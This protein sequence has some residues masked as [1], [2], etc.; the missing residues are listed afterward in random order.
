M[1]LDETKM[2]PRAIRAS[3][4]VNTVSNK[5]KPFTVK[6]RSGKSNLV[7]QLFARH[8][9]DV[10]ITQAYQTNVEHGCYGRYT[11]YKIEKHDYA[12][13]MV[14]FVELIEIKDPPE[15]Y[16]PIVIHSHATG[17]GDF[18]MEWENLESAKKAFQNRM[19]LRIQS[20]EKQPGH[21]RTIRLGA[22]TPWFYA[23]GDQDLVGDYVLPI[24]VQDDSEFKLGQQY[25]VFENNL[26]RT[27]V[28]LGTRFIAKHYQEYRSSWSYRRPETVETF[29]LVH[30]S[31]GYIWDEREA[32]NLNRPRPVKTE[33]AWIAEAVKQFQECLAG[34]RTDVNVKFADG[35]QF[36][37]KFKSARITKHSKAG[38]YEIK[39]MVS[40]SGRPAVFREGWINGFVPTQEHPD[41]LSFAKAQAAEKGGVFESLEIIRYKPP[42]GGS[43]QKWSGVFY[44]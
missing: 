29:R 13:S 41:V 30:F 15:G 17:E 44:T 27:A 6:V 37:G 25:V 32:E 21:I 3:T 34:N 14:N 19:G 8:I 7:R 38:D 31:D 40:I 10:D 36:S 22:L 23:V 42:E 2:S 28:C 5:G 4:Y 20:L 12:A 26:P 39:A 9:V 1:A 11:R 18:F 35:T 24:G 33:E 16:N 43:G